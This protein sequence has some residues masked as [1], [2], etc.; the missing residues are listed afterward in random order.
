MTRLLLVSTRTET[1][2][3]EA[4]AWYNRISPG[5]G[6]D[7]LFCVEHALHR[8]ADHPEA[9]ALV[10]PDVRRILVRRFP[11]G[12]FFRVRKHRIEI[13]ALFHLRIDP[14]RLRQRLDPSSDSVG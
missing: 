1:D 3:A 11:F 7:F 13:E 4:V 10:S 14:D 5:I 2:L 12:L 8:I 9:F 6:A